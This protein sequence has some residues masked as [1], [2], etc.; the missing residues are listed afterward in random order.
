MFV[1][2]V[3]GHTEVLRTQRVCWVFSFKIKQESRGYKMII[4]MKP[5][6][7]KESLDNVIAEAEQFEVEALPV[8]GK[9]QTVVC[10]TGNTVSVDIKHLEAQTGV[11]TVKRIQEPYKQV[12]R[13][14]Y[15]ED[16][17][18]DVSGV[19]IGGGNFFFA[20]GPC[21]VESREQLMTVAR[22][23]KEAGANFLRG[24]VF[25]PRTSPYAFQGMGVEGLLLLQEARAEYS[26]PIV[27]EFMSVDHIQYADM[28]DMI[29]VGARNMQN[30]EFLKELG[31]IQT[32]ILL[33]RGFSNTIEE[34]L[35]SAEY[36]MAGGN[37]NVILCER[38]IRTFETATRS[39]L[40]VSAV[41][42][43]QKLSHLP[44]IIDPSHA[45]GVSWMV[46]SLSKSAVAVGADGLIVEVHNNPKVAVSDAAQQLTCEEFA[47][48]APV[49]KQYVNLEGKVIK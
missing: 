37:K 5:G 23:V 45:P 6:V 43:L 41:P 4:V 2:S 18:I 48:L 30:F 46:P 3:V 27:T 31:K 24:G 22:S 16:T 8:I 42:V 19:K 9:M 12:N 17:V 28:V 13:A 10:L 15:Q 7:S 21:S 49:I 44:V 29:Q 39:T 25:K 33:K 11:A 34:F 32:P 47:E 14:V 36:I 26:L 38:G 35:M 40:D 1:V 20:A